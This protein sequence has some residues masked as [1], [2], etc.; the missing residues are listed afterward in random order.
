MTNTMNAQAALDRLQTLYAA[1]VSDLRQ[2][3]KTFLEWRYSDEIAA[4]APG[5]H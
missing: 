5:G 1:A 3:V 2:A 4:H